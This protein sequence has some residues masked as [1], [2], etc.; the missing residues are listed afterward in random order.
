MRIGIVCYPTY[1]GS[2]AAATELGRHLARRGHSVHLI[3]GDRPFR[4]AHLDFTSNFVLHEIPSVKYPVLRSELYT[5]STAVCMA[6]L[7][8]EEN[9]DILHSHYAV[10]HAV[11]AVLAR[12]IAR[13][14][15]VRLVTTLHGTDITLV[16]SHPAF[17]PVVR[18]GIA[19]SDGV[20]A[21]S[22]WL[23]SEMHRRFDLA[24][25]CHV[26]H[27]FVDPDEYRPLRRPRC[28]RRTLAAPGEKIV[29]HVSNFRP[30]KRVADVVAAFARVVR[31][32]PS[33][34]VMV[35]D[36]PDREPAER[37]ARELGV[38]D[39]VRFVGLQE[40]VA[41]LL[42]LADVFL[43]PSEY[44]SFGLAALEAMACET[45]VVCSAS[46]GLP[47]VV[48]DGVSGYLC[49]MGDVEAMAQRTI[50]VLR[51]E[52]RAQAM[53][54]AARQ[55]AVTLFGPDRAIRAHEELYESLLAQAPH[56]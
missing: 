6:Q 35:G 38:Y 25:N 1:G 42:D 22:A 10:P 19:E 37:L 49:P 3:S 52:G 4:A 40:D 7:A 24:N 39:R 5:L 43:F 55:R 33:V 8:D 16:G 46:G 50:A 2:G 18:M 29:M 36:G 56:A 28:S 30:V 54:R 51:E 32:V 34:L 47:E 44:E 11:S 15:R 14:R 48:E 9:L 23:R 13:N 31:E 53:G 21:V 26:I 12:H 27:N 20:I 45:P 17:A 41:T